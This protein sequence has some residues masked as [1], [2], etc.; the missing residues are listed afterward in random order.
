MNTNKR[1][2]FGANREEPAARPSLANRRSDD[3]V[4]LIITL[5]LLLL[6][7][8]VSLAMVLSMGSDMLINGYYRNYRGAYYAADSGLNIA[9]QQLVNGIVAQV[10]GTFTTP[11]LAANSAST[12][13]NDISTAYGSGYTSL[14]TGQAASSWG[15]NFELTNVSFTQAS[16]TV[17]ASGN[18]PPGPCSSDSKATA[19]QYIFNYSLT[20][21][22]RSLASQL[23]TVQETGNI[24]LNVIGTPAG[25]S[26]AGWGMFIDQQ[27]I[28]NGSYL[29]PG[30]ITGPVFTNGS[31]TF[32][33]TGS[34]IFTDPVASAGSKAGYQFSNC[35]QSTGGSYTSGAQQI[36]PNFEA[37][38]QWGEPTVTL[39][40]NDFN[41]K[42]AAIDGK[43]TG[44]SNSDPTSSEWHSILNGSMKNIS[45]N[46]Y[47]MGGTSSGVYLP[48]TSVSGTNTVTGGGIYVEGN[49]SVT[50]SPGT[51]GSGNAT[52]VYTI[53]QGS[54]TT[55]VTTDPAANTTTMQSG[56]TTQVLTGIP[57]NLNTSPAQPS[58]MLY[59][60]GSITSLSGPG[61][62]QPAIQNA[63]EVTVTA[64]D[65]ITITGDLLYTTEPVTFTENQI[66]GTP[67]DTVI[68]GNNTGQALG[69][70]TANGNIELNNQQSN[71]NLE[72]DAS[73]ATISEGGSG[74]LVNTGRSINT[75]NI[76]G[77]RIQNTIQNINSTTR[78]VYFDRRFAPGSGFAPPWFPST[79]VTNSSVSN[80]SVA[81]VQRVSWFA[82]PQ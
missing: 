59:V 52:Q 64:A 38:Y 69:I 79:T 16:C 21:A 49:A 2:P 24:T 9:R 57:E 13:Q 78:N 58:T 63:S 10:P 19:Y 40:P 30:T 51:D 74:G 37:G 50:L 43:G 18:N 42:Y 71:N 22:G 5:L 53:T 14:N 70:F 7:S 34:Y 11:P 46:A 60:N 66:P 15:G 20:A 29:V 17:T 55:T 82:S 32:G 12:V 77:G 54:T 35:Y 80:T 39:P 76:V 8:I 3:G 41:Q 65:N 72:L 45:G 28:C 61:Q 68:P 1:R 81:S 56:S 44:E 73:L 62:G 36:Q 6:M 23:S 25:A 48:Y 67:A 27:P 4:A 26:F 33:T 47:P 75:L 31:W